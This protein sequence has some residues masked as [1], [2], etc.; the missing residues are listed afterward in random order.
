MGSGLT[1]GRS[2]WAALRF[3]GAGAEVGREC[4]HCF[5]HSCHLTPLAPLVNST[6]MSHDVHQKLRLTTK[7][8][9]ILSLLPQQR[10]QL[11]NAVG[12]IAFYPSGGCMKDATVAQLV[13]CTPRQLAMQQNIG[14]GTIDRVVALLAANG[15]ALDPSEPWPPPSTRPEPRPR[16]P[17]CGQAMPAPAP[18]SDASAS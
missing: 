16:C 13:R 9:N 17:H 8:K 12:R 3:E 14:Q 10:S 18:G 11:A 7:I 4:G 5:Q 15:M 1:Q 2:R 6:P